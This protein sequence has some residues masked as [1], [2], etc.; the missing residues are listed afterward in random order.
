VLSVHCTHWLVDALHTGLPLE[1]QCKF[2]VHSTQF[3][4]VRLHAA[5][6]AFLAE[7]PLVGA[8]MSPQA[9]QVWLFPQS[10]LL[11]VVHW[12][13]VVQP[14][15]LPV[16]ASQVGLLLSLSEQAV[17]APAAQATHAFPWQIGL[18]GS[19]HWLLAVQAMHK[20]LAAQKGP[21]R[22]LQSLSPAHFAHRLFRQSRLCGEQSWS[23]AQV[24]GASTV[25]ASG[26]PASGR[27]AGGASIGV[28]P[29]A[30]SGVVSAIASG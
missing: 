14:T 3:P 26:T 27:L 5:R 23:V 17:V 12:L 29:D 11:A 9:A 19:V 25:G 10:G 15:H 2:A 6:V 22:P 13:L 7:Q 16:P 21:D 24:P 8:L 1:V 4:L 30:A 28:A 20:P 18:V